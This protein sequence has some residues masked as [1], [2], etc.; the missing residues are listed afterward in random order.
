M[1][2]TCRKEGYM[3]RVSGLLVALLISAGIVMG[4]SGSADDTRSCAR[5]I[6]TFCK[7]I[8]P[9]HGLIPKCL[10]QHERDLSPACRERITKV[11]ENMKK[12]H[13]AC[14]EDI[15]KFCGDV[16]PG[17]GS[18]IQCLNDHRNKISPAC[19][20]EMGKMLH[21]RSLTEK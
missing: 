12:A 3:K 2:R 7:D 8:P 15:E 14:S 20:E 16:H 18:I 9:V 4:T 11:A 6:E 10:K 5:E 17:G 19:I 21:K 13:R 1:G